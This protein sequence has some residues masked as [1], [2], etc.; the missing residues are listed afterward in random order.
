MNQG[1]GIHAPDV[2]KTVSQGEVSALGPIQRS[3]NPADTSVEIDV[4][5]A[6][7]ESHAACAREIQ[8]WLE[9]QEIYHPMT[10]ALKDNEHMFSIL[11]PLVKLFNPRLG[12]R[13]QA[14]ASMPARLRAVLL[15]PE[16]DVRDSYLK[17]DTSQ[18]S[19]VTEM[20]M[21]IYGEFQLYGLL[22][23]LELNSRL[24]LQDLPAQS[25]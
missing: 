5:M 25:M 3:A 13:E 6:D 4:E 20:I 12:L 24:Q 23:S 19:D 11:S 7:E 18:F 14:I 16:G 2:S 1:L 9:K 10:Q 21:K 22:P 15:T 8:E 17:T